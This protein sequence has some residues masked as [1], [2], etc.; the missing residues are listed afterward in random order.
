MST[1]APFE[2]V[3]GR[4]P[5]VSAKLVFVETVA[6]VAGAVIGTLVAGFC[7]WLFAGV[8]F[9][10]AMFSPADYVLAL[11]TVVLF[12]V[13]Y[14]KLEATPAV[15]VSLAVGTALPTIVDRFAF[16]STLGLTSLVLANLVFAVVALSTYRFVHANGAVRDASRRVADR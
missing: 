3:I 6:V 1:P 8:P 7:V 16:G 12:A 9:L 10:T 15:L 2:G 11:V 14:A 4:I 5:A 13:F